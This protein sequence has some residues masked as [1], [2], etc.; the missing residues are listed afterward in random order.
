MLS[1][2]DVLREEAAQ[3]QSACEEILRHAKV[4]RRFKAL[5]GV[6]VITAFP[7][8]WEPLPPQGRSAQRRAI[9][10]L[11][12]FLSTLREIVA[13]TPNADLQTFNQLE[14]QRR[15]IVEQDE[16]AW[17][18]VE[19]VRAAAQATLRSLLVVLDA[20]TVGE[21]DASIV[22][23]DTNALLFNPQLEEWRWDR[24]S[25]LTIALTPTV[26]GELDR[27]KSEGPCLSSGG[28]VQSRP[29]PAR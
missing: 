4:R 10:I 11:D 12:H 1:L 25:D 19:Q 21:I 9:P 18:S 17:D 13:R 24:I 29:H 8:A 15:R 7:Y 6:A 5:D 26:L 3:I 27:L 2:Y 28:K 22:V 16:I 14:S 23:P 20:A